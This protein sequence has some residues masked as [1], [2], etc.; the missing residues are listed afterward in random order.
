M[1]FSCKDFSDSSYY[2]RSVVEDDVMKNIKVEADTT[3]N[4]TFLSNSNVEKD[5][6]LVV[7]DKS[8]SVKEENCRDIEFVYSSERRGSVKTSEELK[9]S[10]AIEIVPATTLKREL[11]EYS[12]DLIL[13]DTKKKVNTPIE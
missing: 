7:F 12:Y 5:V 10:D 2:K 6:E 8:S 3:P 11:S 9:G 1:S 4:D 13:T